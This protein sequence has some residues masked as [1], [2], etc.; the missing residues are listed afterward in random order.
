MPVQRATMSAMSFSSTSSLTSV[1]FPSRSSQ[2]PLGLRDLLLELADLVLETR[3]ALPV[4]L[5][6]GEV[7]LGPRGFELLLEPAD[8]VELLDLGLP[9]RLELVGLLLRVRE[10]SLDALEALA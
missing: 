3:R 2:L 1:P 4:G 9:A 10:L 7:E 6:R 5:A 8:L